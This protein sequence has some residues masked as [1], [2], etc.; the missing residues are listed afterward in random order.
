MGGNDHGPGDPDLW[1]RCRKLVAGWREQAKSERSE[2][3]FQSMRDGRASAFE[4]AAN[5]LEKAMK[6]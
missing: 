2:L 3:Q 4:E 5:A 1:A 6:R